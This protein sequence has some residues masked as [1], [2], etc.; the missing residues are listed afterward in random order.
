M[1]RKILLIPGIL[2]V[3][4]VSV[5]CTGADEP[6]VPKRESYPTLLPLVEV[7][8]TKIYVSNYSLAT[9]TP[10]PLPTP[11]PTPEPTKVPKPEVVD[12]STPTPEPTP[13]PTPT[14]TPNPDMGPGEITASPTGAPSPTLTR[15][16][17]IWMA[18]HGLSLAR[19]N[20]EGVD[21]SNNSWGGINF[22]FA[23]LRGADFTGAILRFANFRHA[24]LAG[25]DLT[26]ADLTGADLTGAETEGAIF[27]DLSDLNWI[28]REL[29]LTGD[30][31]RIPNWFFSPPAEEHFIWNAKKGDHVAQGQEFGLLS[32]GEWCELSPTERLM[33]MDYVAWLGNDTSDWLDEQKEIQQAWDRCPPGDSSYWETKQP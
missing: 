32:R 13:I 4:L 27:R 5:A 31:P 23:N 14:V 30:L 2:F 29:V 17:V 19:Q 10:T 33:V 24:D 1:L 15:E 20:L 3:T 26:G 9:P 18:S 6:T 7:L 22:A 12:R 28:E 16:K 8:P 25:A 21:L 11:T